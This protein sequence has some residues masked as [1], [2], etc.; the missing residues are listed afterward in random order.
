M[1]EEM[2]EQAGPNDH[3]AVLVGAGE[4]RQM[5]ELGRLSETL[6]LEVVEVMEQ[7]RHDGVGY[8]GRGKREELGQLVRKLG[9]G[10]VVTDDE[11]TASQ[12]RVLERA[13]GVTVV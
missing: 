7:A 2:T 9:V 13:A 4:D 10:L 8:L 5:G 12:A 1:M 3:R 11:L 6:G